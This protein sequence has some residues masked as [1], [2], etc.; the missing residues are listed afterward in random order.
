LVV[1]E[2]FSGHFEEAWCEGESAPGFFLLNFKLQ[3]AELSEKPDSLYAAVLLASSF[4]LS[5]SAFFSA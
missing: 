3:G 5:S 1:G 4:R 2:K